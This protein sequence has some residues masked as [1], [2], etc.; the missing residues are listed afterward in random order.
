MKYI[1]IFESLFVQKF[2]F[3]SLRILISIF[4]NMYTSNYVKAYL[5]ISDPFYI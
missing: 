1:Y 3:K 2:S 5:F 4:K